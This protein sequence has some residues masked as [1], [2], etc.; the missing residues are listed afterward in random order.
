MAITPPEN[1]DR[2]TSAPHGFIARGGVWVLAQ[3]P[4]LI[5]A[6]A[7]PLA[8]RA[9]APQAL[10]ILGAV[11]VVGGLVLTAVAL[12]QL[13]RALTP[14]P[15]PRADGALRTDGLYAWVR[16]PVYTGLILAAAGWGLYCASAWGALTTAALFLFFDRKAAREERALARRYGDYRAY[17]ARVRKLLPGIY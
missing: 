16:H 2:N 9:E 17:A 14:F 11:G 4:L 15:E 10:R 5:A 3:I 6:Y 12:L 13:R 1:S 7:L 8:D